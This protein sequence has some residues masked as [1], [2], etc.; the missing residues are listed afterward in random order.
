MIIDR[1]YDIIKHENSSPTKF[2]K[3]VGCSRNTLADA[4]RNKT[5]IN[6]K[7]VV[8]ILTKYTNYSAEWLMRGEGFMLKTETKNG[9][10]IQMDNKAI[11]ELQK[12]YEELEHRLTEC[13]HNNV[14]LLERLIDK[15]E[16]GS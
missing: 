7:W 6:S 1:I 2:A 16:T 5:D 14:Q 15:K 12:K 8:N 3:T 9:E 11:R 13:R 10:I 4:Y